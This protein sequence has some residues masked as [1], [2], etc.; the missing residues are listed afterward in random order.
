MSAD[1]A[2]ACAAGARLQAACALAQLSP[3][4][5]QRWRQAGALT[6]DRRRREHRP[7]GPR[8][9]PANRLC[10]AERRQLLEVANA[11]AFAHLSPHQI[12]PALADGGRYL[13]SEATFYRVLRS[14]GQLTRRGRVTT[15]ARARAQPLVATGPNQV[16]SWDITYLTTSVRGTFFYLYL[17]LDV[18]SRKIVGW[19]VYE[20]ECTEHAAS[21]FHKAHL[22]EGVGANALVLHSDNGAPMKGATMLATLQ[23]LGV[24]PSFSRP[25]VSNDNPYSESLFNTLKGHS[26]F[27]EQPFT[28]PQ[29]ARAWVGTFARCYNDEH[30]HSALRFV[31]PAQRHR[32]EDTALLARRHT[33]YQR[34]RAEHPERWSGA[35][36]NWQP[37][38][39]VLLNPGKPLRAKDQ[40]DTAAA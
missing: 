36:R 30:H 25:A 27:P 3:R 32:G 18:F 28:S 12:V 33:L 26:A 40:S 21:V 29:A 22:R 5:L 4:T 19:E 38:V 24:V 34:A 35:T 8:Q 14:A 6:A 37:A 16:W 39:E 9:A 2:L 13:A 15:P 1:I 11:P 31:T 7:A 23:R 20:R 10:E 17:I